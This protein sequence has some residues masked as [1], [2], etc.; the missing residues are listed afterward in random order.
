MAAARILDLAR[1]RRWLIAAGA[2]RNAEAMAAA[3]K[4]S[5]LCR[6]SGARIDGSIAG[7]AQANIKARRWSGMSAG[8]V[9]ASSSAMSFR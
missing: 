5:T 1:T 4:P 3:S 9:L 2:M 8:A 6:I 7:W